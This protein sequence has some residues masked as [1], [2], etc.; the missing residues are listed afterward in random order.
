MD[1]LGTIIIT[2]RCGEMLAILGGSG[3]GKTTLLDVIACRHENG[4]AEGEVSLY[5]M[6]IPKQILRQLYHKTNYIYI[7]K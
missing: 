6:I 7:S 3:S 1:F 4:F 5:Y 2:H